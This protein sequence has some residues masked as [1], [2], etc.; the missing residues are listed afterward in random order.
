[1]LC[2]NQNNTS[3]K[4]ILKIMQNQS[5]HKNIHY[6]YIFA[7]VYIQPRFKGRKIIMVCDLKPHEQNHAMFSNVLFF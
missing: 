2:S 4:I 3:T 6:I 5:Y 7:V 1:M